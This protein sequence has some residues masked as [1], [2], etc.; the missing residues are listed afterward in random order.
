MTFMIGCDP[1]VF[2]RNDKGQLVT[3]HGM[4]PG[5][6]KAPH[7]VKSGA[8]QVDGM[9]LE[10]NIDPVPAEDFQAFDTAILTVVSELKKSL[11]EGHKCQ[12]LPSAQFDPEYYEGVP[13]EAKELGCDPDFCA[14]S[15]DIFETNPRPDGPVGL[16]SAAGHIHVGWGADIPTDNA[17]HMEICRSFIRNLD[18]Y[19]GLGMTCIDGDAERR[20]IYGCA[21]AFRPKSYGVEYR[22]P[23]NVWIRNVA[24]RRF[25][26]SLVNA[27]I[28]DMKKGAPAFKKLAADG[29]D[30]QAII[31][32]GDYEQAERLLKEL[33]ITVPAKLKAAR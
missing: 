14:Y 26:H 11:P 15:D 7:K 5:D 13:E 29:Y 19:V 12:V 25:V 31:N 10:F 18:V 9:A 4:I 6:K 27:A 24:G 8:I 21:G 22:T 28:N 23:S 17:D 2:V 20:K 16:R 30:V 32:S 1:E 3:A 33:Y